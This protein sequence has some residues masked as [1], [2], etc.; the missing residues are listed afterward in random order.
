MHALATE[1]FP[2]CRSITGD[3]VRET[4]RRD[5]RADPDRDSRGAERHG[6][7]RL[8]RPRRVE[9]PRS[10]HRQAGRAARRR[11]RRLESPRRRLQRAGTGGDD[12]D[13]LRP[14]LH[15]HPDN[16]EWI[17]YRTSYYSRTWGFCLSENQLGRLGD[18]PF[19]VVVDSTLEPGSLT[20]GELL[21]PGELE[22]EVLLTTHVCH[23]S[24]AND[25]LSG[26]VLLTELAARLADAPRR[27]SY[28]FLFIPGTI[29]SIAWLA[30]NENDAVT[31]HGWAGGRLRR[32]LRAADLQAKPSR[33]CARRQGWRARR[34]ARR[35]TGARLRA[36]GLGRAAVQ[37]ARL[38]SSRRA[39]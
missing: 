28:R 14:H 26:I 6:G 5:R 32:R 38:R 18:G 20:Y 39:V 29:G 33:R 27:L 15:T 7:S 16:P 37:F 36:V 3:G 34:P 25:N 2:I 4:L 17:P 24:L 19:E 30:A 31:S 12:L 23:P 8:D 9:H 1:L 35:W 13:E 10:S 22:D 21:L 11:L